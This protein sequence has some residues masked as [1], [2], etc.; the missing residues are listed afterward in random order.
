MNYVAAAAA[1]ALAVL[2]MPDSRLPGALEAPGAAASDPAGRAPAP[3]A[4]VFPDARMRCGI[5]KPRLLAESWQARPLILA[6]VYG[7][8]P[9]T[10]TEFLGR[11]RDAAHAEGGLGSDYSIVVASFLPTDRLEHVAH[12]A[13][14][15]GLTN[16]PSW[17]F[18]AIDPRDLTGVLRAIVAAAARAGPGHAFDHATLAVAIKHGRV[19]QVISDG[20]LPASRLR[21]IRAEFRGAEPI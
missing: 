20:A 11:L 21:K 7:A 4:D 6:L 1:F 12:Y 3:S 17:E 5:G 18:C 16:D 15:L 13:T 10:C 19:V 9:E 2:G 14:R 8:C